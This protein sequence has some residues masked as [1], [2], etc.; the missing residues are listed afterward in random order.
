[1]QERALEVERDERSSWTLVVAMRQ[2]KMVLLF[3]WKLTPA[4]RMKNAK[5]NRQRRIS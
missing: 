2:L 1:M 3:A 5:V 4:L